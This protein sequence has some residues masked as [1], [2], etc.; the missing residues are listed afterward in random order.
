MAKKS[1]K[2]GKHLCAMVGCGLSLGQLRSVVV[3]AKFICAKCGRA[4]QK[5]K[6]LCSPRK[7]EP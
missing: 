1:K 4:A 6:N 5:R 7:L 3:D 2:H